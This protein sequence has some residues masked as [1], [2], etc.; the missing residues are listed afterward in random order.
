MKHHLFTMG[1]SSK[2]SEAAE[3]IDQL[4]KRLSVE[5]DI[6]LA[7]RL[8]V[9]RSTDANWRNRDAVSERYSRIADGAVDWRIELSA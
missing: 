5:T 7:T 3:L 4:K 9:S 2:R 6:E 1:R 8:L